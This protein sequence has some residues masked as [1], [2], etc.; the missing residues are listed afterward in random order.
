M[1]LTLFLS[2]WGLVLVRKCPVRGR[3]PGRNLRG[4]AEIG[5]V[6]AG[7]VRV[8]SG[9]VSRGMVEAA[10]IEPASHQSLA[11]P[12]DRA[13]W[14]LAGLREALPQPKRFSAPERARWRSSWRPLRAALARS[15]CS[16]PRIMEAKMEAANGVHART[17]TNTGEHQDSANTARD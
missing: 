15:A 7:F 6:L 10:G 9:I 14:N 2:A 1:G 4:V 5:P 17:H 13:V 3:R 12:D 16:G 11:G 8:L